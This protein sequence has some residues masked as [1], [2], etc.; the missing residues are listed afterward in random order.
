MRAEQTYQCANCGAT[1]LR[2]PSQLRGMTVHCSRACYGEALKKRE[3]HNKG[4]VNLVSKPCEVCGEA[5]AGFPSVVAKRKYCSSRCVADALRGSAATSLANYQEVGGCWVWQGA[6]WGGYG[7]LRLNGRSQK[8]HRTS[9]EF[10]VGPIPEGLVI[11]HLCRN[12]ACINPAHLEPVTS[13][14]NIR[15]GEQGSSESMRKHWL[16]RKERAGGA[17]SRDRPRAQ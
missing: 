12:R 17:S 1:V 2:Y 15:R 11:D 13:A 9:Y 3:P 14:E 8:A 16:T 4:R 10:H 7:N 5:I 6:T